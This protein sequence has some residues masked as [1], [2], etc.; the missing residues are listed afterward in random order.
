MG[1]PDLESAI[2]PNVMQLHSPV[3]LAEADTF[4][5]ALYPVQPLK[6]FDLNTAF[7]IL[8]ETRTDDA[9]AVEEEGELAPF[10]PSL[11]PFRR[12]WSTKP[13]TGS[14]PSSK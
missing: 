11:T 1:L 2:F 9:P 14:R 6:V 12:A 13:A 7:T 8:Q 5:S 4:L 3:L 10:T